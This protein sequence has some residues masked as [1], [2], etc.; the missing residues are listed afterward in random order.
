M[1]IKDQLYILRKY[2]KYSQK[3]F[4]KILGLPNRTY[5]RYEKEEGDPQ[6]TF[7]LKLIVQYDVS[8][9]W[10]LTGEGEMFRTIKKEKS[11]HLS[12]VI[13]GDVRNNAFIQAGNDN[14]VF[15]N[16]ENERAITEEIM[17][18]TRI[19]ESLDMKRRISLFGK[20]YAL[21]EEMNKFRTV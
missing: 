19:F 15:V 1:A 5:W 3:D 17:E 10:L 7:L 11:Q 18:L 16:R 20:A 14:T 6:S 13:S 4:A 9:S 8:P 21:E 12:N 2:L